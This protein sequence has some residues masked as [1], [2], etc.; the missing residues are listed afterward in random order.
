[1]K[2]PFSQF[3]NAKFNKP[4]NVDRDS[5]QEHILYELYLLDIYEY[6]V[7]HRS[8]NFGPKS[9]EDIDIYNVAWKEACEVIK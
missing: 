8:S 1:M 7:A 2:T 4:F 5:Y 3:S 6:P 9:L